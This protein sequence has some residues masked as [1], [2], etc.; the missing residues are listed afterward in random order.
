MEPR[1]GQCL[2]LG[3]ESLPRLATSGRA[4]RPGGLG[5]LGTPAGMG[6]TAATPTGVGARGS[7]DVEPD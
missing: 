5:A 1:V 2:G 4:D 3:L 6:A 7:N